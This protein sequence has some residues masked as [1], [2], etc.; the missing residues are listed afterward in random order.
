MLKRLSP[1]KFWLLS[2]LIFLIVT[3]ISYGF[4]RNLYFFREDYE[5]IYNNYA[6]GNQAFP[7]QGVKYLIRPFFLLFGNQPS[8]YFI[9]GL[10]LYFL[11][12]LVFAYFVYRLTK[13]RLVAILSGIFLSTGFIGSEAMFWIEYAIVNVL[14]LILVFVILICYLNYFKSHLFRNWLISFAL[15]S[16]CLLLITFRAHF[17]FFI[18]LLTDWYLS[19]EKRIILSLRQIFSLV[20]RLFPFATILFIVYGWYPVYIHS[21]VV[22]GKLSTR[23]EEAISRVAQLSLFADLGNHLVPSNFQ[24]QIIKILNHYNY[25]IKVISPTFFLFTSLVLLF[26]K[27]KP[28]FIKKRKLIY[29]YLAIFPLIAFLSA[30]LFDN[31]YE[32][33]LESLI[34][35]YWIYI[36]FALIFL[37]RIKISDKKTI[38]FLSLCWFVSYLIFHL[39]EP[40]WIHPSWSKYL[41]NSFPFFVAM[42]TFIIVRVFKRVGYGILVVIILSNIIAGNTSPL[43]KQFL[44]RAFYLKK[45]IVSLKKEVPKLSGKDLFYFDV[46]ADGPT[47]SFFDSFLAGGRNPQEYALAVLYWGK[48]PEVKIAR[49]F[50]EFQTE[51]QSG[52]YKN[53][54]VFFYDVDKNLHNLTSYFLPSKKPEQ[55]NI[56][57]FSKTKLR[58]Y[59]GIANGNEVEIKGNKI[60]YESVIRQTRLGSE[61][62]NDILE[63]DLENFNFPSYK[64]FQLDIK[65]KAGKFVSAIQDFPYVDGSV[66]VTP[67]DYH[68]SNLQDDNS[69]HLLLNYISERERFRRVAKVSS[70]GDEYPFDI[71]DIIDGDLETPWVSSRKCDLPS[72]VELELPSE[73]SFSEVRWI[74]TYKNRLPITYDYQISDKKEGSWQTIFSIKNRKVTVNEYVVDKIPKTT[75]RYFRMMIYETN[76]SLPAISEIELLKSSSNAFSQQADFLMEHPLTKVSN[77]IELEEIINILQDYLKIKV[78]PITDKFPHKNQSPAFRS[79]IILDGKTHTYSFIFPAGG[80]KMKSILIEFPNIPLSAEISGITLRQIP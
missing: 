38:A 13:N 74:S 58:L 57:D 1:R 53:S 31:P 60:S 45:F 75:S 39:Q 63:L 42:V 40:Q 25:F 73:Y 50:D 46:V 34:G 11:L 36:I 29:F 3:L 17:L 28:L 44:E 32:L 4:V 64:T 35:V 2:A 43:K 52:I 48:V 8:G 19:S 66:L 6:G 61:S 18:V 55:L 12:T 62:A 65:L 5:D 15:Y 16:F 72:W 27:F 30:F 80:T 9:V 54:Y 67:K 56:T 78:Y 14:Y 69:R 79:N 59:Y 47:K 71:N 77:Q 37:T 51:S 41:I 26:L 68:L 22:A 7:V 33:F 20:K 76:D 10:F 70:C 23:G 24:E 49:D 21:G